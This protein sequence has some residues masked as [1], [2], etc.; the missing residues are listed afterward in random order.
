MSAIVDIIG[1]EIIDSRGNPTV[2]CDVLLESGVMGRAAVPSGASTGSREAIELRDGDKSRYGG[3]G[4]L[5]ACEHINT[6]ISEAIMGLDASEQA[7]LD[8]TLIDLDGTENKGRLGANAMLAVS[9]AV[10]KAAAEEAGLPLYR[11][12][13]GS[14]AMQMPV[15]MMNVINGGEHADNNLDI[16]EFM[17]I[18]VGAPSF[19]EAVRYG[20][21]VFHALKKILHDKG[22]STS[23]GD[24]GG[25]APNLSSHEEALKLIIQAIEAAGY[26][27]GTQIALGLDCAASEFYKD[28]SYVLAGENMTLT[29]AQFTG[30]LA[31]WCDKYPIISIE[32]GMAENDWDGWKLLTETLGKKIQLV[33]DDLFVTNTK[34]LK[35]GIDKDIANSILIKINQIG[36]LTE[37]FAAI[38][39]AKRAGYTAVIS[40]RSGETEDSTIADIAVGMNALQIKTGSMSRSDR[41]AK[42]NQLL[43]IEEDLGDIA[44][45]PGRDAFYNLK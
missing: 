45:Y 40:H 6:E 44:S 22:L 26:E 27:P 41:M 12:F 4:V 20:A 29:G 15:P 39:M 5:K 19:R 28:G 37:T 21:E 32:D 35:E 34:I 11:Y 23:V 16:Q 3:K 36:T 42:Y 31:S 38:E 9:M 43:R 24:E 13:G 7:F 10:A 17:I 14:G 33:G 30:L 18:P 25:F 2:E 1:R 8:R